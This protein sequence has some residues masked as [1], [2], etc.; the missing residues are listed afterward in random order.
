M[1]FRHRY[2]QTVLSL[3]VLLL[4]ASNVGASAGDF[5]A[6][7]PL[8]AAVALTASDRSFPL[9]RTAA[10]N[11]AETVQAVYARARR[12]LLWMDEGVPTP[13]ALELVRIFR[14][15]DLLGLR[16]SNYS[17]EL[18]ADSVDRL[19]AVRSDADPVSVDRLLAAA[20]VR[21][22][23]H[24]HYGRIDPRT[25]GFELGASRNDLDIAG[26]VQ[27]MASAPSVA[28]LVAGAEPH[29][30]HYELL[31]S[32]LARYRQLAAEPTLTQLPNIGKRPL[33]SGD[34]YAGAPALR[35]LLVSEG[36]LLGSSAAALTSP[37][38]LDADLTEALRRFQVRHG[39]SADGALNTATFAALTTPFGRRVRQIELTLERWRWLPPFI[40]PPIIVNIPEFR[41][42]AFGSTADRASGILQMPVIVGQ[43][44][45]SKRTPIF[46]ADMRYVYSDPTGTC[47]AA[48]RSMSCF[49]KFERIR[50]I[51]RMST[52]K[53]CVVPAMAR[54]SSPLLR[55]PWPSSPPGRCACGSSRGRT[56][57]LD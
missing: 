21:F 10:P 23:S 11:E 51:S 52:C 41:L 37:P 16:P 1:T 47:R 45:P 44:N 7:R 12:N 42:F 48:S 53:W 34:L 22:I 30:Y 9:P 33:R 46:L 31:K 13:Q 26:T 35:R 27:A 36:D 25:A 18:I 17:V 2:R 39:L 50:T 8:S 32:A 4:L 3:I 43:T 20:A 19:K 49:P 5:A 24:V 40:S 55:H 57:P 28:A 56:M 54:Q 29:F 15:S 6:G 38:R 14:S